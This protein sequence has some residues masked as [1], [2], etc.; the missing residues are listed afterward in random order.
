MDMKP[1]GGTPAVTTL[2]EGTVV[3]MDPERRVI[4]DGAVAVAGDRIAEIG[5]AAEL[6]SRHPEANR[7]GGRRRFVIPGLIDCHNHIAQALC[8]ES[9]VEDFPNIYRIYIPAEAIQ[10]TDDVRI[11]AQVAFAQLMRAGVT[12]MTETTCTVA[13]EE[14]IAETVMETGIRCALARGMWDR[15][16][17]LAGNYEQITEKS[18]YRDDPKVLADDLAYTKEFFAKWFE[19]GGGRL[20][21]WVHNLGVPSCSD[22]RFLATDELAKEWETGVMTHINR[23]REEIELSV[24]LFGHRPLEHLASI[25]AL[26]E[27]L[28]AI[29]AMLTT[30][31]EIQ[32]M[33]DAGAKLAHAPVVCTDI[34][35]AVTRVPLMRSLGITVGLGCDTIINDVLKLM[36]IAFVMHNQAAMPMFD[37]YGF[38]THD[39]FEMGTIDAARLLLWD[40]EIGSLEVGKAADITV[41]DANNVRLTP[42]TDPIATLVRYGVGTDAESVMVAGELTVH[43]GRLLTID[44]ESLIEE[45]ERLGARIVREMAPRRYVELGSNVSVL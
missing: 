21:P 9:T 13:H 24:S 16:S 8:R 12:T 27:R 31:R 43:D 37:P 1:D 41:I 3:T 6:R 19:K 45:A 40:D 34:M 26:T 22:E 39:A 15:E 36:R 14:P 4:D 38:S 17:R 18:W 32:L 23:D 25:G 29:H 44:E 7:I 5:D 20:R 11:S 35:S 42:S 10:S 30:D 33:A 2:V 28:V